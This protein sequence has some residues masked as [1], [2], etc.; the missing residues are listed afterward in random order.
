MGKTLGNRL[1]VLAQVVRIAIIELQGANDVLVDDERNDD[2]RLELARLV[3][4]SHRTR[5]LEDA[6]DA[7]F[8]RHVRAHRLDGR[9]G[10]VI[11]PVQTR[12]PEDALAVGD[13]DR[14][15]RGRGQQQL[16]NRL[17][18]I[19][20]KALPHE[21]HRLARQVKRLVGLTCAGVVGGTH[22]P[23]ADDGEH[24]HDDD[25][26]ESEPGRHLV[27]EDYAHDGEEAEDDIAYD[28]HRIAR[29]LLYIHR[30]V[31]PAYV[32]YRTYSDVIA[33]KR[34]V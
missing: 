17:G 7:I 21:G 2:A 8:E 22:R 13:G 9:I 16:A 5:S 11:F 1:L 32:C 12:K 31:F 29:D 15:G 25:G 19:R 6:R 30:P 20:V 24:E 3:A 33:E 10:Q 28:E 27:V 34:L 4:E 14:I 23:Q 18:G 26:D